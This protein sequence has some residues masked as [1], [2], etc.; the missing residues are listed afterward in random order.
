[1]DVPVAALI[2]CFYMTFGLVFCLI[3]DI[4]QGLL[5]PRIQM[6]SKKT[7]TE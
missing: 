4:A 6:G 1:M 3:V 2:A 7:A 5:D